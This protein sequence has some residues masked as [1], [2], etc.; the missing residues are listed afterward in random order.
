MRIIRTTTSNV[1]DMRWMFE[2][3]SSLRELNIYNFNTSKVTDMRWMFEGCSSLT[4]L[5]VS[6]PLING[7]I[8]MEFGGP[9][10][11]VK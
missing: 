11:S 4:N 2:G 8:D 10:L 6:S 9:T 3:C 7:E 5:D 1:E